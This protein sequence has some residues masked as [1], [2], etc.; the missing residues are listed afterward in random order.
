MDGSMPRRAPVRIV[1][2][3]SEAAAVE[4]M[5]LFTA[6]LPQ[7]YLVRREPECA[8]DPAALQA[9][10]AVVVEPCTTLLLEQQALRAVFTVS[11]GVGHVLQM[12]GASSHVPLIRVEDAGMAPQMVRYVLAAALRFA[13][14]ADRYARQQRAG[15]WERHEPRRPGTIRAGV[16][17]LGVIGTPV[18][19]ALASQGFNVRGFARTLKRIAGIDCF[20]EARGFAGF[21]HDLDFLVSVVPATPA[22]DGILNRASLALL[23]D[24]AHVV[25]IGRG[26]AL[27]EDDLLPLLDSG[28]LSGATLDVFRTE[29]LPPDHPFWQREDIFVTPHVSGMTLHAETVAQ[30]AAKIERCGL[31]EVVTGIVDHARGY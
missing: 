18:A 9:D 24:G 8:V 14:G 28:K 11:A 25:N 21:L 20:D 16:L 5:P 1:A 13:Q 30:I 12:P 2:S 27:V 4:W 17:G 15:R 31:G 3:L 10:Y 7:A 6:A 26:T 22:T 29:P 23:A 19:Q